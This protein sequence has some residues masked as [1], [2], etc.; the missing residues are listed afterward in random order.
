MAAEHETGMRDEHYD[1]ISTLYHA[2]QGADACRQYIKD[3]ESEGDKEVLDFFH[4]VQDQNRH[5]A[6]KAKKLLANR[7]H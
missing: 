3:A 2:L 5:L 4:E 6:E 1:I 7:V